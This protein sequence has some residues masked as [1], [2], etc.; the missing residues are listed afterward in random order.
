MRASAKIIFIYP[1]NLVPILFYGVLI[2]DVPSSSS[3]MR[4]AVPFDCETLL[5]FFIYCLF[6]NFVLRIVYIFL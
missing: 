2:E 4:K 6:F 3:C 1:H 5:S